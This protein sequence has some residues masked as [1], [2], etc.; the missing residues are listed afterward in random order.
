ML[1][2]LVCM[3]QVLDPEAP[4]SL[5][6]IDDLGKNIIPPPGTMPVLSPF[7]ENALEAALK[8]KDAQGAKITV[9]SMGPSLAKPVLLRVVATGADELI[10]L[11]DPAFENVDSFSTASI[12]AAAIKRI[13][14]YD[15]IFC[16]RQAADTDAGLVGPGIAEILEI[17]LIT[18]AQK[19]DAIGDKLRVEQITGDGYDVLEAALPVLIT[20]GNEMGELRY[21]STK[22]LMAAKKKKPI[23]WKAQDL[24]IDTISLTKIELVDMYIPVKDVKCQMINAASPEEAAIELAAQLRADGVI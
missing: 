18:M 1:N 13:N 7:D 4:V 19:V 23:I 6:K 3:K 9:L 15:L 11:E 14:E 22:N 24:D 20:V 8:I 2:I 16:G 17:P 12:L 10:L 5:F 21:P